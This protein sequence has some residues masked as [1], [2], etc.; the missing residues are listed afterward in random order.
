MNNVL[1]SYTRR[2]SRSGPVV[3]KVIRNLLDG[4]Q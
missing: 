1:L 4:R 2:I 3:E